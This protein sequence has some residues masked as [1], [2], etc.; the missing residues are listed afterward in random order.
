MQYVAGVYLYPRWKL[1]DF[2]RATL[3]S[4]GV[5][6]LNVHNCMALANYKGMLKTVWL[7]LCDPNGRDLWHYTSRGP[8]LWGTT[9]LNFRWGIWEYWLS[10]T[11]E[12]KEQQGATSTILLPVFWTGHSKIQGPNKLFGLLNSMVSRKLLMGSWWD[13]QS[14]GTVG[15]CRLVRSESS[16]PWTKCFSSV[17]CRGGIAHF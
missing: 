8:R 15:C 4:S 2:F 1:N 9:S 16:L 3:I 14:Q 10:C 7:S 17:R 12:N 6:N 5:C 11:W 13:C